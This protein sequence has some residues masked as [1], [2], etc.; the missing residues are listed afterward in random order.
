MPVVFF[1]STCSRKGWRSMMEHEGVPDNPR[2]CQGIRGATTVEA[3]R[4]EALLSATRELI[5]RIAAANALR[6]QD[7]VGAIF[8][9]TPDL[10]A[11]YPAQAAREAGWQQVPL[12][13]TQEMNVAG[14]LPRCVRVLIFARTDRPV[15]HVYLRDARGLRPDWTEEVV[16]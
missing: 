3:N 10:D 1:F 12:L 14:S 8:T 13:C 9:A 16:R 11:A 2:P 5:E 7:V 4:P 6:M 15:Q